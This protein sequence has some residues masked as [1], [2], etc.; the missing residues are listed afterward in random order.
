MVY[1]VDH[2][3]FHC[4]FEGQSGGCIGAMNTAGNVAKNVAKA[5]PSWSYGEK[6]WVFV[7][8][9]ILSADVATKP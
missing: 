7:D 3:H 1:V 5:V 9:K 6:P 4:Q 2:F 8:S